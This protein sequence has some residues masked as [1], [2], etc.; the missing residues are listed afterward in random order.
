MKRT[1]IEVPCSSVKGKNNHKIIRYTLSKNDTI[2]KNALEN[3]PTLAKNL[4][5]NDPSGEKR[6][7]DVK[8]T[9]AFSGYIAEAIVMNEINTK[10]LELNPSGNITAH[11]VEFINT[12]NKTNKDS[13]N[14]ID[15]KVTNT[16]TNNSKTIEVRSSNIFK[17]KEKDDE[18][19]NRDQSLIG[20]YSTK[21]KPGEVKKDFYVTVFFR[22]SQEKLMYIKKNSYS[23]TTDIAGAASRELLEKLGSK[24]NLK[25]NGA[26]YLVINP[27]SKSNSIHDICSEI[28]D[29]LK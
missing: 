23:F 7:T 8:E 6:T 4:N 29:S 18:V 25:Q 20:S 26:D 5:D 28:Y 14:Q 9:V 15:I 12:N 21:V 2:Y 27:I 3:A 17:S 16:H 22:H 24:S 11:S 10:L 1:I 19:Y 13:F